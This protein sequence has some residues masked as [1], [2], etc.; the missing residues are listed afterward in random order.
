[1][2]LA[3]ATARNNRHALPSAARVLPQAELLH[4]ALNFHADKIAGHSTV[5]SGCDTHRKPLTTPHRHAHLL[6]LDLDA[7]GHLD[8]VLI[9]APMGLDTEAQ[10]AIRAVRRTFMKGGTA[11]LRL[12]LVTAGSLQNLAALPAPLGTHL[13]NLI[14]GDELGAQCWRSVTP[15]VPPRHLKK[16]GKNTLLGQI[17]AE[18]QVRNIPSPESVRVLS[19]QA[20]EAARDARRFIRCRRAGPRPPADCGFMLELTFAEAVPGPVALGYGSHFGL[21]LFTSF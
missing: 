6:H 15:F 4:Q 8:H 17:A 1:M 11:P 10:T 5:L 18:L 16:N 19:P 2:L 7:D 3:I 9:W 13:R 14:G 20:D 21:G 12:G